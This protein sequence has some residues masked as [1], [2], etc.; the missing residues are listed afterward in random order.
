MNKPDS[1]QRI[2][3]EYG[4]QLT[5][6]TEI[7]AQIKI[8]EWQAYLASFEAG[9]ENN[10]GMIRKVALERIKMSECRNTYLQNDEGKVI[11]L[12]LYNNELPRFAFDDIDSWGHLQVLFL[13][14]NRI[15]E[16][17]LP[18]DLRH[19]QWL[20]LSDNPE[21]R[22]L[23]FDAALPALETV[24]AS[25]SGL[26]QIEFPVGLH[27]LKM[28]DLSRNALGS[29][30]FLGDC[31]ALEWLDLSGNQLN[32]F[33]LPEGF[34]SLTHLYLTENTALRRLHFAVPLRGLEV[35]HLG[36]CDV[37]E[38][39]AE[40]IL[41]ENL[42]SLYAAKNTPK[43]IPYI[44]LGEDNSD[45][46]L[47][48]ARRWFAELRDRPGG[49]NKQVK[50]I[51]LG[52]GN[53]GK[54]T[55]LCAL[56]NGKCTCETPHKSTHAVHMKTLVKSGVTF[57]VWDFGGQEVYH[58][59]HR[60][61]MQSPAVQVVLFDPM[62]EANAL[63]GKMTKDRLSDDLTS[64]Q[65]LEYWFETAQALSEKSRFLVVQNKLDE[66]PA[67]DSR[68][69][70]YAGDKQAEFRQISALHGTGV[71]DVEY[72]MAKLA[73]MLPDYNMLMPASW[74]AVRNYFAQNL[75]AQTP[76]RT[77]TK[78]FYHRLCREN[79][80]GENT[81]DLL[82]DY[83]HHSG[84]IYYHPNLGETIIT[85]QNWA[86]EAIYK[87]FDR[88]KPWYRE[89]RDRSGGQIIAS[90]LFE[91]FGDAYTQEQ[92]QLFLSFMQSCGICFKLNTEY[93]DEHIATSDVYVFTEFL[94]SDPNPIAE[95]DWNERARDVFTFRL[96][97]PWINRYV[98]AAFI[99]ALGRKTD[100]RYIWRNGIQVQTEEGWFKV[101][102]D[103]LD[104]AIV[105]SVE[106]SAIPKWLKPILEKLDVQ[107][108]ANWELSTG[109]NRPFAPFHL[110]KMEKEGFFL[111]DRTETH[112]ENQ[113]QPGDF[114]QMEE[115]TQESNIRVVLFVAANPA[116]TSKINY[117]RE[118]RFICE[119][120]DKAGPGAVQFVPKIRSNVSLKV[121]TD[122][123]KEIKP[124]IIHFIGHGVETDDHSGVPLAQLVFHSDDFRDEKKVDSEELRKRFTRI[125]SDKCP[126]RM[127]FLNACLS[128]LQARAISSAGLTVIG[129]NNRIN[130][131]DA[132]G[133]AAG[134]YKCYGK[135]EDIIEAIQYGFDYV[136]DAATYIQL[137]KNGEEIAINR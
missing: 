104:K 136:V 8:I 49:R 64:D 114:Q 127:V 106:R 101:K 21:L 87:V 38:L 68:L 81:A 22:T 23:S 131:E 83:L 70:A 137:F 78:D 27:A 86:L 52:N 102:I 88:E 60:L 103:D 45:N 47:D 92:K 13:A 58:G 36:A 116:N 94:P 121:F 118:F 48:H 111:P 26:R 75:N 51:L 85:D 46:C 10:A 128:A 122:I 41:S 84:F 100:I 54:S 11:A 73:K 74:L 44:F 69:R 39:P 113:V 40:T 12:N 35:L 117:D 80:V 20:D 133:F 14:Q 18:A 93:S 7:P 25:D 124:H 115:K 72:F 62:T 16:A 3:T 32:C 120:M 77:V 9:V 129:S 24:D 5:E 95:K 2:E 107:G 126:L 119:E 125:L 31:P 112:T 43:N 53:A 90:R 19:L 30:V 1:I 61:F 55:L 29:A 37:E 65:P 42:R 56:E 98:V 71:E 4:L 96:R 89:F 105:V 99:A 6:L 76:L 91:I 33:D 108:E 67:E 109:Q 15:A 132:R 17:H 50:L 97:L 135:N 59:T 110:E 57:N 134:F 28:I 123:V 79:K 66:S 130:S 82:F 34:Q 63:E